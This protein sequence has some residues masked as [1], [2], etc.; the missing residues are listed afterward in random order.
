MSLSHLCAENLRLN[1]LCVEQLQT[2]E[3]LLMGCKEYG[4]DGSTAVLTYI[5]RLED[6]LR[7]TDKR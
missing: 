3:A 1:E 4:L 2:I 5:A 6:E 7:N